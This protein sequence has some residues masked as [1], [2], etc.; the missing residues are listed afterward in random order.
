[1]STLPPP[2]GAANETLVGATVATNAPATTAADAGSDAEG[3]D[4]KKDIAKFGPATDADDNPISTPTVQGVEMGDFLK[5]SWTTMASLLAKRGVTD[6]PSFLEEASK[7]D[8]T[9]FPGSKHGRVSFA[10]LNL[11]C[12]FGAQHELLTRVRG[13]PG[14]GASKAKLTVLESQNAALQKQLADLMAKL[15]ALEG[16]K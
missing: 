16:S 4:E 13:A 9:N 5:E 2:P 15:S 11:L 6:L 7:A 1:M 10:V 8:K 3:D 12:R 14:P